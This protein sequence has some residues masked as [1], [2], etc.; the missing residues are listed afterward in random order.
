LVLQSA[1]LG[2]R[3][4]TL[5][6]DMGQPLRIADVAHY[7]IQRSGREIPITY[8]GLRP[9]EKLEEILISVDEV[10]TSAKHPLI[11]HT[12]VTALEALPG[13]EPEGDEEAR[14]TMQFLATRT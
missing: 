11:S 8:A 1:V 14:A 13:D 5:I 12:R 4:E 7:M 2:E 6:L 9:G 10:T 3:G